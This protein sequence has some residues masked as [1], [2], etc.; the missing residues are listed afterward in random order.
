M[1]G[2]MLAC[3]PPRTVHT[4]QVN[5]NLL[6]PSVC[7]AM[8]CFCFIVIFVIVLELRLMAFAIVMS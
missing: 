6:H 3:D 4:K 8:I 5:A 7:Y 1:S 2:S